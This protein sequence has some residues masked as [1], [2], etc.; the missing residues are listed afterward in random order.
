[1]SDEIKVTV[2][3]VP[4]KFGDRVWR[5]QGWGNPKLRKLNKV[6]LGMWWEMMRKQIYSTEQAAL[7]A[8]VAEQRI[9]MVKA[10]GRL[11]ATRKAIERFAARLVVM[12]GGQWR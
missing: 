5:W 10:A 8:A 9:A 4:V 1:M 11:R 12:K 2:D 7:E 3:G 6:D